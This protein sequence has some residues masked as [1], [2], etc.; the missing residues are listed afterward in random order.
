MIRKVLY[1]VVLFLVLFLKP[2]GVLASDTASARIGNKFF[3]SLEEAILAATSTDTISLTSNVT[4]DKTLEIHK[5]VNINLNNHTISGD[6]KVFLVQGGSLNLSGTGTIRE[7]KPNYGA[8]ILLGSSDPTKKDFSTVSV[9]SGVTLEGWSGIFI[10]HLNN[11]GYGILVNMNGKINALDDINGGPGA[12]VYVN[13]NIKH[14][15]NAPIV[16]LGN[17]AKITSTGNGIY[18]AGYATYTINGAY[19]SGEESGLGIKS[20]SFNILDGTIMGTGPDKT[21]T[22]GNNNGINASGTAIQIESNPG[23]AGNIELYIKDG[24]FESKNSNVIYEYTT[25]N[26]TQVKDISISSGMFTSKSSKPVFLLSDSFKSKHSSFISGGVYTDDPTSYLKSGY[27]VVLEQPSMYSVISNTISVF[28][29][30]GGMASG[31]FSRV[32]IVLAILALGVIFYFNRSKILDF[33]NK[34]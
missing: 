3:D 23:Y 18:A 29:T 6:E 13:G 22:S 31:I 5:T 28:N 14:I 19:I 32:L 10:N 25:N 12:G 26:N 9:S 21:P 27:S 8:V 24:T 33:I 7:L 20:G 34:N 15:S 30:N 17:T 11:T 1:L 4:F 16:N 2:I